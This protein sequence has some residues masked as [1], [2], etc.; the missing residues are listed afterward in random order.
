[1]LEIRD[2]APPFAP[3]YTLQLL[4][5]LGVRWKIGRVDRLA[6]HRFGEAEEQLGKVTLGPE[7]IRARAV[8][9]LLQAAEFHLQAQILQVQIIG[10]LLLLSSLLRLRVSSLFLPITFGEQCTHHCFQRVA[11]VG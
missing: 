7:T 2:A 4:F 9:P 11:V 8:I 10:A 1:M 6:V 5:R 3:L